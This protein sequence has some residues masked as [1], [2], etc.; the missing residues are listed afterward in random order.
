MDALIGASAGVD[1]RI[2]EQAWW[3]IEYRLLHSTDEGFMDVQRAPTD[4]NMVLTTA[5][6][7]RL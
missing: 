1:C 5:L 6:C 3:R 2:S 7:L 4:T